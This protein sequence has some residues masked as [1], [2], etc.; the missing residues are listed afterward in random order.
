MSGLETSA[1]EQ[2]LIRWFG[3]VPKRFYGATV[4]SVIGALEK[5]AKDFPLAPD[6]YVLMSE[7]TYRLLNSKGL[8]IQLIHRENNAIPLLKLPI[9]DLRIKVRIS[10]TISDTAVIIA[11]E[12]EFWCPSK[13]LDVRAYE[14]IKGPRSTTILERFA[15]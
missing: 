7:K 13:V 3:R 12:G 8:L 6:Q 9:K 10:N 14:V 2:F 4:S 5:Y 1:I 15:C 11:R